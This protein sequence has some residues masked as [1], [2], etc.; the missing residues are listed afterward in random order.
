M[1]LA[2]MNDIPKAATANIKPTK[3]ISAIWIIPVVALLIGAWMVYDHI[4][5]QGVLINIEFNTAEGLEINKTQIKIKNVVIGKVTDIQLND[6]SEKISVGA[7]INNKQS[8]LLLENSQFWVVK[9]RIG[10]QGVSGLDTLLSGAYIEFSPGKNGQEQNQFIGLESP[11]V[12]PVGTPGLHITLDNKGDK[13]FQVGDP[14]LFRGITT[15]KI[16]HTFFNAEERIVYYNVFIESP[17]DKLITNN[18]RFWQVNGV[19]VDLSADGIR[20]ETGT[21]QTLLSGGIS[22]DIPAGQPVG[23]PVT[24][25]QY[26][27][28]LPNKDAINENDYNHSI[29]YML[30]FSDSIRGL[31]PGAPVEFRGV[32]V[33]QVLRTDMAY[34]DLGN[35]LDE[36]TLIPIMI[37]I[38]PARLGLT[39]EPVSVEQTRKNLDQWLQ[40]GLQAELATGNLLT[41]SKIINLQYAQAS[42]LA[43]QMFNSHRVIPTVASNIDQ[44][45]L[46]ANQVMDKINKLPLNEIATNTNE[47][48]IET[49]KSLK[50]LQRSATKIDEIMSAP[51]S[52]QLINTLNTTL[53]NINSIAENYTQG[54]QGQKALQE[55]MDLLKQVLNQLQPLLLQLNQQPNSLIFSG[56]KQDDIEPK[57]AKR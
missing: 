26:F 25:R 22:F 56:Q 6:D 3:A 13:S 55:N 18:T 45:L 43:L 28:I 39:D 20:I 54:S 5:N 9:P 53:S 47:A 49:T 36:N 29:K 38:E 4:S 8:S 19:E 40:D 57:G 10:N 2:T 41:G 27:T 32:K 23:E 16:E 12:T 7:R 24:D 52:Q 1:W 51:D 46:K 11:P 48:V 50:I 17:Y 15:G 30:L 21:V 35:L 33:G 31:K 37:S 14:I 34:Q 44:I 42:S